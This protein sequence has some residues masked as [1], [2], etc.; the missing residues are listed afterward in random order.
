VAKGDQLRTLFSALNTRYACNRNNIAL[1]VPTGSNKIC[2]GGRHR[3]TPLCDGYAV[4]AVFVAN[5]N[6][7]RIALRI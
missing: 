3:Y 7:T 5:I 4:C 6:H 2:S 1:F